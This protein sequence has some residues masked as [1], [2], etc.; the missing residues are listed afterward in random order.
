M[1]WPFRRRIKIATVV[2]LNLSKGGITTNIGPKGD[3]ITIGCKGTYINT[4]I[5]GTGIYQRKMISGGGCYVATAVY[6]SY[7]CP[8]VWT[9]RRFRDYTLAE[10][11]YG[12]AFVRGYYTISPTFVKWFGSYE[13]FKRMWRKPLDNLISSLH[14]EGVQDTPYYD[15]EW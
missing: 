10:T 6:G 7:D 9:L 15:R 13:W 4:S 14:K 12:R 2:H 11:W 1:A 8:E 5:P 3:C